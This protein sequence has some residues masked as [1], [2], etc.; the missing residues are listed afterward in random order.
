MT[1]ASVWLL[2]EE[3]EA[4]GPRLQASGYAIWQPQSSSGAGPDVVVLTAS[5]ADRIPALRQRF[6]STPL[7]LNI[8]EDTVEARAHCLSAG[9]D[10]FWLSS[11]GPSD[12]LMRLRLQLSL[13]QSL[14][15]PTQLLQVADLT[16]NPSTRDV[17]RGRRKVALTAREYA[18]LVLL[19]ERRGTVVSRDQI[20]RQVWDDKQATS[21]NVIEVYVRYLRQKLEEGGARR[22]IHTVRGQGYCLSERLPPPAGL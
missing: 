21:S 18:L 3:A 4:L 8:G 20:L 22:L 19:L 14:V 9:A 16:L 2:G 12:L 5:Q 1:P 17:R 13:R 7:L 10:D 15:V 11:L 6:G